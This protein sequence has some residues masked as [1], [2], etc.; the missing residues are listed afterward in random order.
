MRNMLRVKAKPLASLVVAASALAGGTA[1]AAEKRPWVKESAGHENFPI[2]LAQNET[3]LMVS[4]KAAASGSNQADG[5]S[6]PDKVK[7][8]AMSFERP[9]V[10]TPKGTFLFDPSLQF[11]TSSSNR[12]SILGYTIVP[13]ITVG[14]ID[15]RSLTRNSIV[16]SLEGRYGVTN[17]LELEGRIPYVWQWDRDRSRPVNQG[18]PAD[19]TFNTRGSGLGDVEF[20]FRYQLN[21]PLDGG[22]YYIAGLRAVAPTGKGPFDVEYG[23]D[24]LQKEIPTGSGFWAV[25]PSIGVVIPSD[26]A[27]FYGRA[28]YQWNI[29]KK[30]DK[31]ISASGDS[32][33]TV[34]PGDI[35]SF[36]FGM[37]FGINE[38]ASFSIG[39]DHAF[40]LKSKIDNKT[41]DGASTVQVGSLVFGFSYKFNSRETANISLGVGVTD[42]APD[43][44]LTLRA[45]YSM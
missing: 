1:M 13:A 9:G 17:R 19:E 5:V 2:I 4:D 39:Y 36:N 10:L 25:Q 3:E 8:I 7:D 18:A 45:P 38:K 27:V 15:L 31:Q 26:P 14:L 37:G 44:Q 22:A 24:S 23:D 41:P 35:L 42:D 21:D 43:V 6:V 12:I 20:G 11:S 30:V 33:G 29:K 40:V 16:A 28:A 32:V 34:D